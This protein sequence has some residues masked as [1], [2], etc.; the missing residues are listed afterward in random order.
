MEVNIIRLIEEQP[1]DKLSQQ[2]NANLVSKLQETFTNEE[3]QLFLASFWCYQN[4]NPEDFVINLDD[5]WKWLG[6]ARKE[7]CKRVLK[8]LIKNTDYKLVLLQLE[9]NLLGGR[10]K[11]TILL[12]IDGFKKLALKSNTKK[13]DE[14]HNYYIK[15]EKIINK[16]FQEETQRLQLQLEEQQEIN[17]TL[18]KR[19]VRKINDKK[20]V[21]SCIYIMKDNDNPTHFKFGKSNNI[22]QR[23]QSLNCA[24]TKENIILHKHWY[25]MFNEPLEKLVLNAFRNYKYSVDSELIEIEQLENLENFVETQINLLKPYENE[26]E[27]LEIVSSPRGYG[28]GKTKKPKKQT[29]KECCKNFLIKEFFKEN[30][31]YMKIC[32]FCFKPGYIQCNNCDNIVVYIRHYG[33]QCKSCHNKKR[34]EKGQEECEFCNKYIKRGTMSSHQES[35]ACKRSRGI[36][37][38]EPPK[39]LTPVIRLHP[40]TKEEE[41]KYSSIEEASQDTG[42]KSAYIVR[43]CKG[44]RQIAG[45]YSW[46][47]LP[48]L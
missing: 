2:T 8:Y 15:L 24:S 22:N 36:E 48:L 46:K 10:P 31:E 38:I 14:I 4:H 28:T 26:L 33:K 34:R 39:I 29:C 40:T 45:G 20:R 19:V 18:A 16:L 23:L 30:D 32:R 35:F 11:E 9:E 25:T 5:V 43:V 1:L 21:A 6:F 27:E 37:I 17:K 41:E 42:V 44:K 3:Q 13:A 7:N 47:F 12:T